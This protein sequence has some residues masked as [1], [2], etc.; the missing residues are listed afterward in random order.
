MNDRIVDLADSP[1]ALSSRGGLLIIRSGDE[2]KAAVPFAEVAAIIASH[3]QVTVTQAALSHLAEAGGIFVSCD[4]KMMPASMLLP[5]KA[6]CEQTE[7]FLLQAALPV[8]RR[9]RFWQSVVRAKLR[10]QASVLQ[11][12]TG[13]DAGLRAMAER[14]Q[15]GDTGNLESQGAR[16]YW[17]L[18]FQDPSFRRGDDTDPRNA[19]LNY[20]YAVL[21]AATARAI[22]AAGLHPS[23]GL[24]HANKFNAFVLADDLMEPWRPAVDRVVAGIGAVALETLSKRQIIAA[25]TARYRLDGESRTLFDGLARMAQGLAAAVQH[26]KQAWAPVE[27]APEEP[28]PKA[29]PQQP[30]ARKPATRNQGEATREIRSA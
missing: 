9:K 22:C 7:R 13:S 3:R 24:H 14:V 5:L 26:K 20:G 17:P 1:A 15:S 8:P 28:P 10:A 25:V 12:F 29:E 18:V 4:E 30:P 11:E 2:E 19:L 16:R 6:H 27:W 21:R 23:F